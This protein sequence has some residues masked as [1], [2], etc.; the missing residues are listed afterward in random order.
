MYIY[1]KCINSLWSQDRNSVY[2]PDMGMLGVAILCGNR[3]GRLEI[4]WGEKGLEPRLLTC[5]GAVTAS[6]LVD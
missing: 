5:N 2:L 4:P 3:T 1:A 6:C